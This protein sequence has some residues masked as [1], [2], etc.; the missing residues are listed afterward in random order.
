MRFNYL[1]SSL[2]K[3]SKFASPHFFYK[4]DFP[5]CK[6]PSTVCSLSSSQKPHQVWLSVEV[7]AGPRQVSGLY[8][9]KHGPGVPI[10]T[11]ET[12]Y[13]NMSS[14]LVHLYTFRLVTQSTI[15]STSGDRIRG[16][17]SNS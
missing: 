5:S 10:P 13:Q 7:Q 14:Y 2:V 3:T 11:P 9:R 17:H 8:F 16:S 6:F 12:C 15:W 1:T 4:I